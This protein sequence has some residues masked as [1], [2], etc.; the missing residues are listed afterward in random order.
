M[1]YSSHTK[2]ASY[3]KE[4]NHAETYTEPLTPWTP[5]LLVLKYKA[6]RPVCVQIRLC[7]G[8]KPFIS[9]PTAVE[10]QGLQRS[11]LA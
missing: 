5:L 8:E 7:S 3:S 10:L 1:N 9:A 11:V 6:V 2:V 4:G